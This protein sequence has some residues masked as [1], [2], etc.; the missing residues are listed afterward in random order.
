MSIQVHCVTI[1]V[2]AAVLLLLA[3]TV[4]HSNRASQSKKGSRGK[5][6]WDG[7]DDLSSE[8]LSASGPS[9]MQHLARHRQRRQDDAAVAGPSTATSTTTTEDPKTVPEV[10]IG[11]AIA[12]C[13]DSTA[14]WRNGDDES[15]YDYGVNQYCTA[16]GAGEDRCCNLSFFGSNS[17]KMQKP[18]SR[19]LLPSSR[20]PPSSDSARPPL[21]S[22]GEKREGT[23]R[24]V[25]HR[26]GSSGFSVQ[27]C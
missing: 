3:S 18:G 26:P 27:A 5:S 7:D 20:I 15:C 11:H 2:G 19:H 10:S 25:A 14:T 4:H 12:G 9:V 22:R 21:P 24:R 17:E 16:V 8:D 13:V 1:A 6:D 23:R